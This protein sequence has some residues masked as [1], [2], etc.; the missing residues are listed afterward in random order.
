MLGILFGAVFGLAYLIVAVWSVVWAYGDAEGRGKSGC[1]VGLLVIFL[2]WPIGLLVWVIF[3]PE[4]RGG[5]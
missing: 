2:A 5:L 1:L 3:R 4:K